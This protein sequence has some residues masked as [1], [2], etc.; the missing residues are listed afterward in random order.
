MITSKQAQGYKEASEFWQRRWKESEA[1]L[2]Q[3]EGREK[4]LRQDL[5]RCE[6][7]ITYLLVII[8]VLALV[9]LINIL[10]R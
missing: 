1:L 10:A 2:L 9:G 6:W 4:Q 8:F 5:D 3:A 7:A